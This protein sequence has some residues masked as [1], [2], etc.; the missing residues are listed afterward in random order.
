[1]LPSLQRVLND[2]DSSASI[3]APPSNTN[4]RAQEEKHDLRVETRP[5][6]AAIGNDSGAAVVKQNRPGITS[7]NTAL[8]GSTKS[9]GKENV[10]A[11]AVAGEDPKPAPKR[12]R[13]SKPAGP[14]KLRGNVGRLEY[15]KNM[16]LVIFSEIC[17]RLGLDDLLHLARVNDRF[18]RIL[19]TKKN[20]H[21]WTSARKNSG[22]PPLKGTDFSDPEWASLIYDLTCV[23]CGRNRA[24]FVDY[25][26]R[27][28][29]CRECKDHDFLNIDSVRA[30]C[31]N[32]G[33]HL[34]EY[35]L[36]CTP[37]NPLVESLPW[38]MGTKTTIHYSYNDVVQTNDALE[39]LL[40]E[41]SSECEEEDCDSYI[42][43]KALYKS[44]VRLWIKHAAAARVDG[45]AH[46]KWAAEAE[47]NR[48]SSMEEAKE[49]RR[50]DI[51]A[52]LLA[53]GYDKEDFWYREGTHRL[54]HQAKRLTD[55]IW[56]NISPT[57]ISDVEDNQWNRQRAEA[58]ER[59]SEREY[60]V[61]KLR[62][63]LIEQQPSLLD[64]SVFPSV[65]T[66]LS[67]ASVRPHWVSDE[68]ERYDVDEDAWNA[69]LPEIE[70]QVKESQYLNTVN[71]FHELGKQ[72]LEARIPVPG[73]EELVK[74]ASAVPVEG[75][76]VK[77]SSDMTD[78]TREEMEPLF[79]LYLASRVC[80]NEGCC[81]TFA[82][83]EAWEHGEKRN[84]YWGRERHECG[85]SVRW[86]GIVAGIVREVGLDLVGVR[87]EELKALG[88]RFE[89]WHCSAVLEKGKVLP[90]RTGELSWSMLLRH[91]TQYHADIFR[92][93]SVV[94]PGFVMPELRVM[95][96]E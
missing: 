64:K 8:A 57:I 54:V 30:T 9:A 42:E 61:F 40:P 56:S 58:S 89:C 43:K 29:W 45:A 25:Y 53:L 79:E 15:F 74:R 39:K 17:A 38:D 76:K 91:A 55:K 28:R 31:A 27:K 48:I 12:A 70:A 36:R 71:R 18:R 65:E 93:P 95:R 35:T 68:G 47:K 82:F 62:N 2:Q 4:Q 96:G 19:M 16:P 11:V 49:Q 7:N 10:V 92:S 63:G 80:R 66:F 75:F 5:V 21:L 1:M 81:Q 72:L 90:I 77:R 87:E 50:R 26:L 34:Y 37:S 14:K 52:R 67:F 6:F 84:G 85:T 86:M 51:E 46:A 69:S 44:V 20:R 22:L 88:E 33:D 41:C 59:R 83:A 94:P 24:S 13:V 23:D 78:L 60:Q 32:D 73:L 3:F